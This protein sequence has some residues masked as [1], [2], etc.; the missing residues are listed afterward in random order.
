MQ[1]DICLTPAPLVFGPGVYT[2]EYDTDACAPKPALTLSLDKMLPAVNPAMG[3]NAA[4][5]HDNL[6]S[7]DIVPDTTDR[8]AVLLQAV[9]AGSFGVVQ[10]PGST[11]LTSSSRRPKEIPIQGYAST[12]VPGTWS[13]SRSHINI[14]LPLSQQHVRECHV[15]ILPFSI[16]VMSCDDTIYSCELHSRVRPCDSTWSHDTASSLRIQLRKHRDGNWERLCDPNDHL[17]GFEALGDGRVRYRRDTVFEGLGKT[18]HW[19]PA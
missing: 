19:R 18:P 14:T 5:D 8:S 1:V 6:A 17:E 13:Q 10:R 9:S 4:S 16:Q 7:V 2:P 11:S 12:S 15:D 3:G